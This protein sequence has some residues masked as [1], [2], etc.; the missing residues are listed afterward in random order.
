MGAAVAGLGSILGGMAAQKIMGTPTTYGPDTSV[1]GVSSATIKKGGK[2]KP[3]EKVPQVDISQSLKWFSEAA[4]IQTKYYND[5]LQYYNNAL[6]AAA[7]EINDGYKKANETLQP[8]SFASNQALNE[9]MR[10]MGLDPISSSINAASHASDIGLGG[11][12]QKMIVDAEKIRNPEE[13]K[14][15]KQNILN[16][17]EMAKAANS[18]MLNQTVKSLGAKSPII[19]GISSDPASYE[20]Q[21][22]TPE[23]NIINLSPEDYA[24]V[25]AVGLGAEAAPGWGDLFK[26]RMTSPNQVRRGDLDKYNRMAQTEYEKTVANLNAQK[27]TLESTI[28]NYNDFANEYTASYADE[29][30]AGHTG[31]QVEAKIAATPGYQFQ[32][33]QGTKAIER[34]GAAAGMLGSGNTLTALTNYGQ[35]LAQN[36]YGL[37]MDN[38]S[39]IVNEGSPAT[40]QISQNQINQGKDYG[41][42][43]EAGGSAGMQTHQLIGNAQAE[44]RYRSGQLYADA[45]MFNANM[46]Y[47]G[48][49]SAKNRE[50]QLAQTAMNNQAPNAMANLAQNKFNYDVFKNQQAGA[51]YAAARTV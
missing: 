26:A 51:A 17:I 5:G 14:A 37:Y 2:G 13:R 11:D 50:A 38:L 40:M 4:E 46:Q 35:Q 15:A 39:N 3:D 43:L 10:M 47:G 41:A 12:I 45:A 18:D 23:N 25:S 28:K 8:L 44:Q 9:Q 7:V 20:Y 31:D 24:K 29:Y 36:F 22:A 6:K 16:N 49:Q 32:M 27:G 19:Q 48:I 34:Q 42:L 33:D 1:P 30:D 21:E